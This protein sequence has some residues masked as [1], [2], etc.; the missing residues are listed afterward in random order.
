MQKQIFRQNMRNPPPNDIKM[1]V[2]VGRDTAGV[3]KRTGINLPQRMADIIDHRLGKPIQ[4]M[5]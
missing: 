2:C 5:F 4:Q 1:M 3:I